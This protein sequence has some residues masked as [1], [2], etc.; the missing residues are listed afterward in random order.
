MN[1][2]SWEAWDDCVLE[3]TWEDSKASKQ[4]G[5]WIEG[6]ENLSLVN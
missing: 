4:E 1:S 6:G 5:G 3:E 2:Q